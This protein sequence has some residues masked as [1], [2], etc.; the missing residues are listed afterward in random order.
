MVSVTKR[1]EDSMLL[2]LKTEEKTR[3]Q[4]IYVASKCCERQ[5]DSFSHSAS[6]GNATLLTMILAQ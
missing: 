5:D 2:I 3:S 1:C 6:R 4:E